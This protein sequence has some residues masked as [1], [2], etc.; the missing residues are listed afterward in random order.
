M[1]DLAFHVR[2]YVP[3]CQDGEEL[4][5][6]TALLKAREYAAML[7]GQTESAIATNHAIDAHECAGAYCYANVPVD[8]LKIAVAYCRAMVQAAFIADHLEREA[9]Q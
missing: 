6:R 3:A 9:A 5:Q 1:T 2:H 7:R 4:E 8:R